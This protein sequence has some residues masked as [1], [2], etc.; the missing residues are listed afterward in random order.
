MRSK[1]PRNINRS[2]K[3][4]VRVWWSLSGYLLWEV[5]DC[6]LKLEELRYFPDPQTSRTNL[7]KGI[8]QGAPPSEVPR[9]TA[10]LW[11]KVNHSGSQVLIMS[12]PR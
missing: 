5:Q 7:S 11:R 6:G 9:P 2:Q 8:Y 4:E 10:L 12:L 3:T 1:Q